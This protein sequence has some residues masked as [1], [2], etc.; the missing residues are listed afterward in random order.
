MQLGDLVNVYGGG[1]GGGRGG[2]GNQRGGR[3]GGRGRGFHHQR[4]GHRGSSSSWTPMPPPP[5]ASA[6]PFVFGALPLAQPSLAQPGIGQ[7]SPVMMVPPPMIVQPG[8]ASQHYQVRAIRLTKTM[9]V[10]S[11]SKMRRSSHFCLQRPKTGPP[12]PP[13]Q[14]GKHV[15]GAAVSCSS[16]SRHSPPWPL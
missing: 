1:G 13:K 7:P 12:R 10:N 6:Q 15:C 8:M 16:R 5:A 14:K 4:G 2:H 9:P 3:G 11:Q